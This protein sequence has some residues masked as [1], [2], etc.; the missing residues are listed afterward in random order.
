MTRGCCSRG[1]SRTV[2]K[3][4]TTDL[5]REEPVAQEYEA[6]HVRLTRFA[7][8]PRVCAACTEMPAW[9]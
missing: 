2:K 7:V 8:L 3:Y 9:S 5:L 4:L 1:S 6:P